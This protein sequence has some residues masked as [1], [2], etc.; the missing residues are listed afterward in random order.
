MNAIVLLPHR[1]RLQF[2]LPS[3]RRPPPP[4]PAR[5]SCTSPPSYH[6]A[7]SS[8]FITGSDCSSSYHLRVVRRPRALR[9]HPALVLADHLLHNR[10]RL[11]FEDQT[12]Y[13]ALRNRGGGGGELVGEFSSD[14]PPRTFFNRGHYSS[15]DGISCPEDDVFSG[16]DCYWTN[17]R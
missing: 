14:E 10:I 5:S 16:L 1:I 15:H 9:A 12:I 6:L 3:A 13:C 8:S 17:T 2:L 4:G 7:L 11:Q